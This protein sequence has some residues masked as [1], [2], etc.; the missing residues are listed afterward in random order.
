MRAAFLTTDV[1]AAEPD[2]ASALRALHDAGLSP[3]VLAPRPLADGDRLDTAGFPLVACPPNDDDCWGRQPELLL[4]AA[5]EAG[6]AVGEAFLVCHEADDVAKAAAAGCRP[7]LV[8]SSRTL[9]VVYGPAE[10]PRKE[11]A[12]AIDLAAAVRYMCA[13][14]EQ[15]RALGPFAFA[16]HP[17]LDEVPR[18][19]V[20]SGDLTKIFFLVTFAGVTLA[21]GI[22]YLLAELYRTVR[23]EGWLGELARLVTLQWIPQTWRGVLFMVLGVGVGLAV[24]RVLA[25][26]RARRPYHG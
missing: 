2:S 3:V 10:P 12:A 25:R 6:V 19:N 17:I 5:T 7:V 26:M 11:V 16:P 21:L 4:D 15:E 23:L 8:L 14:A 22:A 9:D 20:S 13:E 1:V 24:P 18:R